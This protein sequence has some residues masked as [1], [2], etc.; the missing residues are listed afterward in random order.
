MLRSYTYAKY[1]EEMDFLGKDLISL[2]D[3]PKAKVKA[4][5]PALRED[6]EMKRRLGFTR[7][8]QTF[9]TGEIADEVHEFLNA[10]QGTSRLIHIFFKKGRVI[11]LGIKY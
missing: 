6:S 8:L 9:N 7:K 11:E 2:V 3:G 1:T 5:I 10:T 4:V